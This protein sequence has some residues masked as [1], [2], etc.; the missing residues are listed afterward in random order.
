MGAPAPSPAAETEARGTR[1]A[2]LWVPDWP[3][4]AAIA[5][6]VVTADE[7]AALHDG[8]GLTAVSAQARA[9]GVRRG[10]RR[11][12]A[13]QICPELVLADRDEGR[14]VR[15][16]EPVVQALEDVVSHVQV[17]RPGVIVI[18]AGGPARF[19]GAEETLAAELIG[20]VAQVAGVEAQVG[21]ADGLLAAL[22]AARSSALVPVGGGADYL[23]GRD[24][25]DLLYLATTRSASAQVV[26]LVDLLRRLGVSTLGDLAA[27][28]PG[29]VSSRFGALGAHVHRLA[30]G[31]DVHTPA[32][33]RPEPDIMVRA[34]LDPPAQRLDTAAFAARR[35][36]EELN[37][38]MLRRGVVCTRLRVLARTENGVPLDRTWRI[39]GALTARELTDR[40]RWQLEGWLTGRSGQPPS[41][42]LT[43]LELTAE[44]LTPAGAVQDGLWGQAGRGQRQAGRAAL[45]VQHLLGAEQVLTPVLEGGRT[46]RDR[47][48]LVAWGDE[49]RPQRDPGAP[50]PGQIP[51]PLPATVP[52]EPVP[53]R[54]QDAQGRVLSV[55]ER[56]ELDGLPAWVQVARSDQIPA[57]MV[58]DGQVTGW[59]G[60]W[61]VHERW[62]SG[63][64]P[65]AYLQ[66]VCADE[67]ALLLCVSAGSWWVE[68]FYD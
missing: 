55:G 58:G 11:R 62:W 59:A 31:L 13:Q 37:N 4:A 27:M 26:D 14:D 38:R 28:R 21:L 10:M 25:R 50:W 33:H 36:A 18:P 43:H 56:G 29:Q 66:V 20:A 8:R 35:L 2:V 6:G 3:V 52:T 57:G 15:A 23:A 64:V 16:F 40:V 53:A 47:V 68:G 5:D 22:L 24:V 48:R 7:P 41:A 46:P 61:P 12:T 17:L 19:F 49:T 30:R 51:Q 60:P 9:L 32:V 67:M 39:E 44:E 54:L 1:W 63:G 42:A 45:R 34:E 65:K